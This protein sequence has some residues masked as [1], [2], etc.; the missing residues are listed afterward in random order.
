[1]KT[2]ILLFAAI[3]GATGELLEQNAKALN[4]ISANISS[5]QVKDLHH[6]VID[7]I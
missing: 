7:F 4:Q 2:Q 1:L 5:L 3:G 6:V